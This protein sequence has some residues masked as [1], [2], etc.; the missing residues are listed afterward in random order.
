MSEFGFTT[1]RTRYSGCWET[2]EINNSID[3][4]CSTFS[5]STNDFFQEE[6][7]LWNIKKGDL[8]AADVDGEVISIG[9]LERVSISYSGEGNQISFSSR[10]RTCDLVDCEWNNPN[11]EFKKQSIYNIITR[12]CIDYGI[13][14]IMDPIAALT[15]STLIDTFKINEGETI[16]NAIVRLCNEYGILP[17]NYGDGNIHLTFSPEIILTPDIL[18]NTN[19][20]SGSVTYD[21]S[22]RF[23]TYIV[24]GSAISSDDKSKLSDYIQAI[25]SYVDPIVKRKRDKIIL[26]ETLATVK[27]CNEQAKWEAN[28][29]AGNSVSVQYSVEGWRQVVSK[30]L[31]RIN[32]L[33]LVNDSILGINMPMLIQEV[34]FRYAPGSG[35]TTT[36]SLVH[37]DTYSLKNA[38][39]FIKTQGFDL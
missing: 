5:V 26:S 14:V 3:S 33:I 9:F 38:A 8:Y 13:L 27:S 10:D 30:K 28:I 37:K 16:W 12:L 1:L 18:T 15:A 22:E 36:L 21:D 7:N 4:I 20:L 25:G 19:I 24:K 32:E 39:A 11:N 34:N 29:R 35:F 6:Q 17:L 23:N 2:I 31:W